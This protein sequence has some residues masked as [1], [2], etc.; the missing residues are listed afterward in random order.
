MEFINH[1]FIFLSITHPFIH[2]FIH[3][4]IHPSI[5]PPTH[6]FIHSFIHSQD[7][8]AFSLLPSLSC[9]FLFSCV[10]SCYC[11][12]FVKQPFE[13]CH[14]DRGRHRRK[15]SLGVR[16]RH[17][18]SIV[19]A[20]MWSITLLGLGLFTISSPCGHCLILLK[21]SLKCMCHL[22]WSYEYRLVRLILLI[23]FM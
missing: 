9:L 11:V 10:G 8:V 22:T 21:L 17:A 6:S 19:K 3:S 14:I 2:S 18:I 20:I 5:H 16:L 23:L 4:F 12:G 13:K 1:P 15:P 7:N